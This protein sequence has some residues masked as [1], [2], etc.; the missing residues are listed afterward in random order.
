MPVV[1]EERI[2]GQCTELEIYEPSG[3]LATPT[4]TIVTLV[5][6]ECRPGVWNLLNR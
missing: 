3:S 6:A 2:R 1:D 5:H 4:V